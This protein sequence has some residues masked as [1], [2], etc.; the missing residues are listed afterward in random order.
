MSGRRGQSTVEY[1]VTIAAVI[2]ALLG[3]QVYIKRG[4]SGRLRDAAD[5]LGEQYAPKFTRTVITTREGGTT[6]TNSRLLRNVRGMDVLE[7]RTVIDA[8][9]PQ[10]TNRVTNEQVQPLSANLFD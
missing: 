8:A 1:A 6:R 2:A 10:R 9:D 5:S 3:M 7:T 4:M